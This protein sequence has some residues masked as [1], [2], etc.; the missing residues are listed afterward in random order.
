MDK[1]L[2][3]PAK[4]TEVIGAHSLKEFI[5]ALKRPRKIMLMIRAGSSVDE[6]GSAGIVDHLSIAV[7][8]RHGIQRVFSCDRH[9]EAAGLELL[10]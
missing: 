9:F 1:F 7:M 10:F 4:G 5:G 8:K 6:A 2:A 3:G